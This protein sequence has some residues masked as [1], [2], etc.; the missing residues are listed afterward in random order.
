MKHFKQEKAI[1]SA[2]FK[3]QFVEH[4]NELPLGQDALVAFRLSYNV[5]A[6]ILNIGI[7]PKQGLGIN[8]AINQDINTSLTQ[9]LLSAATKG[10]WSLAIKS[11][12][13][14]SPSKDNIVIN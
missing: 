1:N 7:A 3:E 10:E 4:A 13:V 6:G 5:K 9:L 2:N 11:P 14:G 12:F 8:M